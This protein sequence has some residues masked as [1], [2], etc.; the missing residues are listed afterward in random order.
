MPDER[1]EIEKLKVK[2]ENFEQDF[3]EH[4]LR[5]QEFLMEL[6]K[7]IHDVSENL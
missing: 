5:E 1:C 4:A 2:F 3:N 7:N 6:K